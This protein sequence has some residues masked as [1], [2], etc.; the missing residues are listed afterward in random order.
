MNF[1]QKIGVKVGFAS[2]MITLKDHSRKLVTH[3]AAGKS[4]AAPCGPFGSASDYYSKLLEE[5]QRIVMLLE[6][7]G[8]SGK[9]AEINA[10]SAPGIR[11]HEE[12]IS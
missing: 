9:I 11:V 1:L 3:Y 5:Q 8:E 2:T 12:A 6:V 10:A 4:P 7:A